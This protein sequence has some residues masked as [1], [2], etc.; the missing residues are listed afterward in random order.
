M[1]LTYVVYD[2]KAIEIG[3]WGKNNKE[4]FWTALQ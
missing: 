2:G 1:W 3:V 4:K